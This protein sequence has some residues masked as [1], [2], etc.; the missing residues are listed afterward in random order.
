MT[1]VHVEIGVTKLANT[2]SNRLR[3]DA[4]QFLSLASLLNFIFPMQSRTLSSCSSY[5]S[6]TST[7]FTNIFFTSLLSSISLKYPHIPSQ[8]TKDRAFSVIVL[9]RPL[10]FQ[11]LVNSLKNTFFPIKK[12][13]AYFLVLFF[14]F[15]SLF[16]FFLCTVENKHSGRAWS[17]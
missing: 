2:K 6:T 1:G 3:N 7:T 8:N 12:K 4:K 15:L 13:Q 9:K 10:I 14:Y 17:P 11:C 5:P 16:S